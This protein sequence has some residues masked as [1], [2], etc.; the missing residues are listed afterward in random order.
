MDK[1]IGHR[2]Q[3]N[4][5]F[6][7]CQIRRCDVFPPS[8]TLFFIF[9]SQVTADW[10]EPLHIYLLTSHTLTFTYSE[11]TTFMPH[12]TYN[13]KK[14][15]VQ[16]HFWQNIQLR[17]LIEQLSVF[18]PVTCDVPIS[19]LSLCDDFS[20]KLNYIEVLR[21][22]FFFFHLKQ[23]DLGSRKIWNYLK[24]SSL[25]LFVKQGLIRVV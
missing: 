21:L 23:Y 20:E 8:V 5:C 9:Q 10:K 18:L 6:R 17:F 15:L 13:F 22:F 7:D 11:N 19:K 25:C 12:L 24:I 2:G 4:I 3:N 1:V 16:L 14:K